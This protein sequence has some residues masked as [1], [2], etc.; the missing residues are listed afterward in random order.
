MSLNQYRLMRRR[1]YFLCLLSLFVVSCSTQPARIGTRVLICC[2]AG[3]YQTFSVS[4]G[5]MPA[6]LGP[7]MVSNFAVAFA[8]HGLDL[9][10]D[11]ADLAVVLRYEQENLSLDEAS[12][13]FDERIATGN[14]L[15]F[16]AKIVIEV[17]ETGAE[18]I[19]W[20]GQL[21]RI[22]DVGPGEYMHTGRA[23]VALL[24]AFTTALKTFPWSSAK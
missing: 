5:D 3:Q 18:P 22:H 4:T 9:Q 8:S 24:E 10:E 17:R 1:F 12:D 6:F 19:I 11:G 23:S 15:R 20:S 13:D 2:P 16:L 7:I 21:H 14:S